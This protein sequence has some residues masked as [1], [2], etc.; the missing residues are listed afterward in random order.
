[1]SYGPLPNLNGADNG[2]AQAAVATGLKRTNVQGATSRIFRGRP[3]GNF[4]GRPPQSLAWEITA[5]DWNKL[6]GEAFK[7]HMDSTGLTAKELAA[8]IGCSD[9]TIDN[10][11][12]GLCAP[13]GIYNL[14]AIALVPEYAALVRRASGLSE[15][16]PE[17]ERAQMDLVRAAMSFADRMSTRIAAE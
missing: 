3:N 7:A 14:R 17:F 2:S 15:T 5:N 4:R 11:V 10:Y 12:E 6:S 8:E 16:D 13:A 9:R 1:M